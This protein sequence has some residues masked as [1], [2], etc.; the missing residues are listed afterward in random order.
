MPSALTS[1]EPGTKVSYCVIPLRSR[2][3]VFYAL[4]VTWIPLDII[5]MRKLCYYYS[6]IYRIPIYA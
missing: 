1:C 2:R 3:T 6:N 5:S 4:I